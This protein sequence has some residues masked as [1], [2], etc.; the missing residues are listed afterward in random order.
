MKSIVINLAFIVNMISWYTDSYRIQIHAEHITLH[1]N[2]DVKS[3][4]IKISIFDVY[5]TWHNYSRPFLIKPKL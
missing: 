4:A 5:T 2:I 3:V 1:V